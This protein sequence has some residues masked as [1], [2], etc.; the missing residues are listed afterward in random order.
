MICHF[1]FSSSCLWVD[2]YF[3]FFSEYVSLCLIILINEWWNV[4]LNTWLDCWKQSSWQHGSFL[5]MWMWTVEFVTKTRNDLFLL[6]TC[7]GFLLLIFF[8]GIN[9][10]FFIFLFSP[11]ETTRKVLEKNCLIQKREK[12]VLFYSSF[13]S[14]F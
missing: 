13:P 12:T 8:G 3:L 4:C 1:Q 9:R 6:I 10:N 7:G 14:L 11:L 2:Q 5:T